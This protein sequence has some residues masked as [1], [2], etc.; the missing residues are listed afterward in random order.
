MLET[1][2][3][4]IVAAFAVLQLLALAYFYYRVRDD[5]DDREPGTLA[6]EA[7]DVDAADGTEAADG[8]EPV[9]C[10]ECGAENDPD[11]RYCRDCVADLS[12]E[13]IPGYRNHSPSERSL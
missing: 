12:G 9:A 5:S 7:V 2:A 4:E 6:P 8:R 1:W 13:S 11:Y 10:S 3:L